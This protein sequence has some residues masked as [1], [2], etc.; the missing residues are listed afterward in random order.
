MCEYQ[1]INP[2]NESALPICIVNNKLCTLCVLGNAKT[3]NEAK[4]KEEKERGSRNV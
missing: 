4:E 1:R 3:Y 2:D